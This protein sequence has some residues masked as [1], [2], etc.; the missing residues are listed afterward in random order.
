MDSF[1]EENDQ[2]YLKMIE[3][4]KMYNDL[5]N[6]VVINED[7]DEDGTYDDSYQQITLAP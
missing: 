3:F 4:R 5:W 7:T 1:K 2:Y 6:N